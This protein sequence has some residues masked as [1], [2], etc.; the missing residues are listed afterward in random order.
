[1]NK[2]FHKCVLLGLT[3]CCLAYLNEMSNINIPRHASL[4]GLKP[5]EKYLHLSHEIGL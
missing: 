1:M 4:F 2:N 5:T 3:R